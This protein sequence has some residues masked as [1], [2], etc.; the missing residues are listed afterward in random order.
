MDCNHW[1][2]KFTGKMYSEG[3]GRVGAALVFLGFN[4]TFFSQ[5]M[6]GSRGMP[7]RYHTYDQVSADLLPVFEFWH[8]GSTIGSYV[9]SAG[10]FLTMFYLLASLFSGKKAPPNPWNAV[11]MEWETAS[12]AHSAQL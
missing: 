8:R 5:F 4:M 7:R 2:P 11:S 1:W 12:P 9:L 10:L 6:L 3:A